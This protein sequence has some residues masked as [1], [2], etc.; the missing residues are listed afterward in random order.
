MPSSER[1]SASTGEIK[2]LKFEI[3]FCIDEA[4]FSSSKLDFALVFEM[5]MSELRFCLFQFDLPV[6]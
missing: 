3:G 1:T 6:I 5:R 4:Y 2:F